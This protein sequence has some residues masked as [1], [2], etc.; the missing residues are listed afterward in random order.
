MRKIFLVSISLVALLI[1][2]RVDIF[3]Y[4]RP[5]TLADGGEICL[6]RLDDLN[7]EYRTLSETKSGRC[8]IK[9][10]V[11]IKKFPKTELSSDITVSCPFAIKLNDFFLEIGANQ[12]THLGTYNCRQIRGSGILSEHAFG[13]AIDISG[14]NSINVLA[15]WYSTD[16]PDSVLKRASEIACDFFSNVLTPDTDDAHKDHIHLDN[17]FGLGCLI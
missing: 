13:N 8:G 16:H 4:L 15:D 10:P 17:G 9:N 6:A 7:I 1:S 2:L 11:R 12:I 5:L 14:I 3:N